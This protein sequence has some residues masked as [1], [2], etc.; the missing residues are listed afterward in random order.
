MHTSHI[1][2]PI[3]IHI[4]QWYYF[5]ATFAEDGCDGVCLDLLPLLF[6]SASAVA[7]ADT[8]DFA[9]TSSQVFVWRNLQSEVFLSTG[10]QVGEIH[11]FGTWEI[12]VRSWW[13]MS[14]GHTEWHT[15][16]L[17][18][19]PKLTWKPKSA[20]PYA[21]LK[22]MGTRATQIFFCEMRCEIQKTGY[23]DTFRIYIYSTGRIHWA[24]K[25][26]NPCASGTAVGFFLSCWMFGCSKDGFSGDGL[27]A[28]TGTNL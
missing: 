25:G 15:H 4:C 12:E 9:F 8:A 11:R 23:R 13:Q 28:G 17:L 24:L 27:A 20:S 6:S 14:Y 2:V 5:F 3:P 19:F 7:M 22:N 16:L 10:P 18:F 1:N 26:Q 21:P